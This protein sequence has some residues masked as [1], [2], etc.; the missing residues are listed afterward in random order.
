MSTK[1]KE[2]NLTLD[3]SVDGVATCIWC[4]GTNLPS[5]VE[6]IIP[7]PLGCPEGFVL[8]DGE[9]CRSCNNGLAHLD[10]AVAEDFDFLSYMA[11]VPR[12]KG[13]P[14]EIRSRGNVVGTRGLAG[15][16]ISINMERHS[17][18]A[19]DGSRLAPFGRSGRNIN[20]TFEHDGRIAKS[21]FSVS[22]GQDPKFVRGIVKIAFSSLAHFLGAAT[23]LVE[24]FDP[25]RAFVRE[26]K[27]ERPIL[28]M[29]S[30]DGGYFNQVWLPYRSASGHYAI[31]IR[32]AVLKVFVDLSPTLELYPLEKQKLIETYG[33]SGWTSLPTNA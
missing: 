28:L 16:E 33:Q 10:Q 6:H 2:L 20:A 19:H 7:E 4:R 1:I 9:V 29:S 21:S 18:K 15:K 23:V 5:S 13:R 25:V 8:S 27:G 14:P 12:K 31:T 17:V 26:G 22:I 11:G 24:N 30:P 32:L 3:D